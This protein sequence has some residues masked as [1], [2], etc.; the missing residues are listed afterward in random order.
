MI[1]QLLKVF[2]SYFTVTVTLSHRIL[3]FVF[4]KF[5][6]TVNVRFSLERRASVLVIKTNVCFFIIAICF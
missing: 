3:C 1:L 4:A 6:F 2:V 5:V